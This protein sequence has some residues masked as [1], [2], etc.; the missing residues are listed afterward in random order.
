MN[1]NKIF[2]LFSRKAAAERRAAKREKME[3]LTLNQENWNIISMFLL[4]LTALW[5]LQ[6]V[7]GWLNCE[8]L[9]RLYGV[10]SLLADAVAKCPDIVF[11]STYITFAISIAV[12]VFTGYMI[13]KAIFNKCSAQDA[14]NPVLISSMCYCW[15][16][17]VVHIV[18][19]IAATALQVRSTM[20][21]DF[22][23]MEINA[24]P[25]CVITIVSALL[26]WLNK[27]IDNL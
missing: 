27:N 20:G 18:V 26:L 17:P 4:L 22:F 1:K 6:N 9:T 13:F 19:D 16:F 21:F 25:I 3:W 11:Y 10:N 7:I 23:Q 2:A 12:L 24:L 8:S 5:N 15:I 14:L